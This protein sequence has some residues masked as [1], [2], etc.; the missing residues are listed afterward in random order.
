LTSLLYWTAV[1]KLVVLVS[2]AAGMNDHAHHKAKIP[3]A[4]SVEG[5]RLRGEPA[6]VGENP[7]RWLG[8]VTATDP[9]AAII[10]SRVRTE[11]RM[12]SKKTDPKHECA[13]KTYTRPP[14]ERIRGDDLRCRDARAPRVLP[15]RASGIHLRPSGPT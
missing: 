1:D 8:C 9:A 15:W 6:E 13:P 3:C 4:C 12:G 2:P 7:G 14:R 10:A 11:G 5:A